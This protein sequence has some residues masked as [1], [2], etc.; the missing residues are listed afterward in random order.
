VFRPTISPRPWACASPARRYAAAGIPQ[1]WIV[2]R[3]AA[4][5]VAM[6]QLDGESYRARATMPL[7]WLLNTTP[8][9]HDLS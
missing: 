2:D 5:T 8:A 7:A 6:Y 4:Q 1:Y 9:E 3:D